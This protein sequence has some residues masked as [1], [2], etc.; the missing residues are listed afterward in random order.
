MANPTDSS[1]GAGFNATAFRD[2]I[3]STM[4]MGLP[5]TVAERATFRWKPE[6]SYAVQDQAENPYDWTDTPVT[7]DVP[8]DVQ[9][10][11]AVEFEAHPAGSVDTA[12]G[13]FDTSRAIITVLDT[14]YAS[15][16]GANEVLLGENTYT[17]QF[18]APPVGL[19]DVTIYR[20]YVEAVDES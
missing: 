10:A 12:L 6:R 19:F 1:F 5:N 2:A 20:I 7:E 15:I 8:A 11:V 18:V 17:V 14:E 4:E 3:R 16:V 9:V 13:Q